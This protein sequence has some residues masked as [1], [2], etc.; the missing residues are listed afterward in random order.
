MSQTEKNLS[1]PI[2]TGPED[3]ASWLW[4]EFAYLINF[5]L[6]RSLW[7]LKVQGTPLV[8][9]KGPLLVITNH[10]SMLDPLGM[11]VAIRRHMAF[12]AK[13][14][15]FQNKFFSAAIRTLGAV[16]VD[17]DGTG[18][19]GLKAVMN[20]LEAGRAVLVFPEG[21]RTDDGRMKRFEP[22][23][24]TLI[25]KKKPA[26]LPVGIAGAYEAWPRDSGFRFSFPFFPPTK[27]A[28]AMSIGKPL[29]GEQLAA[30]DRDKLLRFLFD[31]VAAQRFEAEKLRRRGRYLSGDLLK[32]PVLQTWP[33]E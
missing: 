12:L 14:S 11:G 29:S 3:R 10:Q 1:I 19:A 20:L 9:R 15:L 6:Y 17:R 13:K 18:I 2:N 23:I 21:T 30:W 22:G 27:A 32:E 28:M 4:Y 31:Q 26:I 7:G 33:E 25:R 5:P 24:T 8:P 16:P